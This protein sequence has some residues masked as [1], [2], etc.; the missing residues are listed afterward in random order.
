MEDTISKKGQREP[1]GYNCCVPRVENNQPRLIQIYLVEICGWNSA[2]AHIY[3][4]LFL[5]SEGLGTL[6]LKEQSL[7]W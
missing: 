1:A 4:Q 6:K 2:G 5:Q 7:Y 3:C